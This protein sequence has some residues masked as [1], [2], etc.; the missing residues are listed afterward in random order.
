MLEAVDGFAD[1]LIGIPKFIAIT[2][3]GYVG[4]GG[5]D[6]MPLTEKRICLG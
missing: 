5:F 2:V 4:N 3:I 6:V 1:T